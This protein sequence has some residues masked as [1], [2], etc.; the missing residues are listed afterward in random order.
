MAAHPSCAATGRDQS[1]AL[2]AGRFAPTAIATEIDPGPTV[3]GSVNGKERAAGE[4]GIIRGLQGDGDASSSDRL[5]SFQPA[6]VTTRVLRAMKVGV[7]DRTHAMAIAA[8]RGFI[9]L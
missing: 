9:H 1:A 6:A 8:R 5:S 2:A 4:V 3:S 7:I